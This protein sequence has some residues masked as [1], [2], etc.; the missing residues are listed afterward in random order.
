MRHQRDGTLTN[1][2]KFTG[3]G[4]D[5]I[6]MDE[7]GIIYI[8]NPEGMMAFDPNATHILTIPTGSGV[9]NNTFAGRDGK[10]LFTTGP[11]DQVTAIRM[12]LSGSKAQILA[13]SFAA[14][15]PN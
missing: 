14:L 4:G 6:S 12:K 15:L 10:T 3:W 2:R 7:S 9:T 1:M 11:L 13:K 5:G 8:S